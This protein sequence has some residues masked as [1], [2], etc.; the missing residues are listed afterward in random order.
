EQ[1][2]EKQIYK[3]IG[4]WWETSKGK[5]VDQNEI[6]IVAISA[7]SPKVFIAEVKRQRKNFKPDLLQQKVETLRTK[8]FYKYEIEAICLTL[9]DM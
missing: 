7:E 6:D 2:R 9:E 5:D 8:L 4:S 3:N 1:L